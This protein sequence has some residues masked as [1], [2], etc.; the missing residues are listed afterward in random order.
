MYKN[1]QHTC[2]HEYTPAITQHNQWGTVCICPLSGHITSHQKVQL[3]VA[4]SAVLHNTAQ[5]GA[6]L[7]HKGHAPPFSYYPAL[8]RKQRHGE[9]AG[10]H[11]IVSYQCTA[12]HSVPSRRAGD[13][14]PHGHVGDTR[15]SHNQHT[16]PLAGSHVRSNP[17]F[18]NAT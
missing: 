18:R 4:A 13:E 15:A 6:C 12:T 8:K 17:L 9:E 16:W 11:N 3:A 14:N 5:L 1:T 7:H 10:R 2:W